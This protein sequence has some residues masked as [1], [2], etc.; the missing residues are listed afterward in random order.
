[1]IG[2]VLATFHCFILVHS[3]E[4]SIAIDSDSDGRREGGFEVV[5]ILLEGLS[6]GIV[7]VLGKSPVITS[8]A[9]A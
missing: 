3:L 5:D 9:M 7:V 8:N 1:M 4:H 2:F 6:H